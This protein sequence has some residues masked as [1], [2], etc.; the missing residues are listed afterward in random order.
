MPLMVYERSE[1]C[2]TAG[3]FQLKPWRAML[4]NRDHGW[5]PLLWVIYLGFFFIQP[6]VDH[7]SLR[8][9]LLDLLGAAVFLLFYFGLFFLENPRALVHVAGM[10]ALGMLYEPINAGAC[11][12]FIFAAA[13]LPF[14][15][16]TQ[17]AAA[18]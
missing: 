10:F 5:S 16:E 3:P 1:T 15:V 8:M 14:C 7:V 9:W 11:T 12:F 4:K 2:E 6:V 18:I 13:M 17:I